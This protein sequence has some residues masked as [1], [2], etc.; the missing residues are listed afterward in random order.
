MKI[1]NLLSGGVILG[2]SRGGLVKEHPPMVEVK[3]Y[4]ILPQW[5]INMSLSNGFVAIN[6]SWL[7]IRI[8]MG[9]LL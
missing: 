4:C 3:I 2:G 9:I 5:K 7:M 6:L 1:L 8:K